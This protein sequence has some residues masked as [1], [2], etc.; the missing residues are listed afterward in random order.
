MWKVQKL[1]EQDPNELIMMS[2]NA[3]YKYHR[4]GKKVGEIGSQNTEILK[5]YI[6]MQGC[7]LPVFIPRDEELRKLKN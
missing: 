1:S 3:Y 4:S 5:T 6:S 2:Q 7:T